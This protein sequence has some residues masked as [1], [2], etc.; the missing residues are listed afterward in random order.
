MP[1]GPPQPPAQQYPYEGLLSGRQWGS[2]SLTYSFPDS[3]ADYGKGYSETKKFLAFSSA[4]QDAFSNVITQVAGYTNLDFINLTGESTTGQPTDG[5]AAIRIAKT[6]TPGADA[7][8]YYPGSGKGG[9]VWFNR[10]D[11]GE[12]H[13]GMGGMDWQHMQ[14]GDYTY[15]VFMH[16]FGHALGLKHSFESGGV[17]GAVPKQYD[18]LEYT[19]MSYDAYQANPYSS[20]VDSR[21]WWA[22]DG[23]NP[24]T[25]MMLD[26]AALQK[27][28]G[29]DYS[30]NSDDTVYRWD[31]SGGMS[32]DGGKYTDL[33]TN[34]DVIFM[35]VWDGGGNDTY[36]FSGYPIGVSIDLRPGHWIEIDYL[37]DGAPAQRADLLAGNGSYWATGNIA[38]SLVYDF[39]DGPSAGPLNE[40]TAAGLI[41]NAVGGSGHDI[42]IGNKAANRLT[43]SGGNDQFILNSVVGLD[44]IVDFAPADDIIGLD[45]SAFTALGSALEEG[46]ISFGAAPPDGDDFIIYGATG[47]LGYDADGSGETPYVEIAVLMGHPTLTSADFFLV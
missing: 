42:L 28:Y 5:S 22:D 19:V 39:N 44:T 9:D 18:S 17:A 2:L 24:Q 47:S 33:N 34:S 25:F 20:T 30:V 35:T 32:L 15:T 14:P 36:D 7:W 1:K 40:A 21:N 4:E 31:A 3:A 38:N 6:V 8:A 46:E 43:G 27:L 45:A 29:A 12:N 10:N 26:I 11:G 13:G 41:E 37:N 16:E 23:D